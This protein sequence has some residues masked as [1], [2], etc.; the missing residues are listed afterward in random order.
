MVI[1]EAHRFPEIG[2]IYHERGPALAQKGVIAF[3]LEH[4]VLPGA[5]REEVHEAAEWF[6]GRLIHSAYPRALRPGDWRR[7]ART[8]TNRAGY[9]QHLHAASY[10]SC[11]GPSRMNRL[12]V[13]IAGARGVINGITL[14]D[15]RHGVPH[16]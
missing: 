2:A 8:S 3:L 13:G 9:R 10:T 4:E 5:S 6:T 16:N 7:P 14:V 12:V 1:G 11:R 15:H